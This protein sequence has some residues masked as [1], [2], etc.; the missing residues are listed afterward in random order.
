MEFPWLRV[1]KLS[2][3]ESEHGEVAFP[4]SL[5][6][7]TERLN[8][9]VLRICIPAARSGSVGRDQTCYKQAAQTHQVPT[10]RRA[11]EET[12]QICVLTVFDS[13]SAS[14]STVGRRTGRSGLR[15]RHKIEL[16]IGYELLLNKHVPSAL[17][18]NCFHPPKNKVLHLDGN[19]FVPTVCCWRTTSV[20]RT[21]G[22]KRSNLCVPLHYSV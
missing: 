5:W 15:W 13:I 10:E 20:L 8:Q 7:F 22:W 2:Q 16:F 11:V 14:S 9:E 6:R 4:K 12:T 1:A 18:K 17:V 19:S 3:H 21:R